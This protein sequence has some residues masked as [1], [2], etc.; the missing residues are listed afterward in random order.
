MVLSNVLRKMLIAS[1]V[2]TSVCCTAT[3]IAAPGDP[4]RIGATLRIASDIDFKQGEMIK[5]EVVAIN[6][7]GGIQGRKI[8]FILLNDKC[9]PSKGV[10]NARQL[11][12]QDKVHL[13]IGSSCSS[14]TLPIVRVTD[15]RKTP[16]ITAESTDARITKLGS[17]WIFRVP[18]S[19]RF[20]K[21]AQ[22]DYVAK[23][24]GKK[25]AYIYSRDSVGKRFAQ[26]T[27]NYMKATYKVDPAVT[28]QV[29]SK[30]IDFRAELLKIKNARANALIIS[31]SEQQ[32]ADILL[33]SYEVGIS[34]RVRR[35]F[36]AVASQQ[37]VHVL[38]KQSIRGA[39]YASSFSIKNKS[40]KVRNFIKVVQ[41][42]YKI[43]PE[44]GLA[45][46]W[47]LIKIVEQA[48]ESTQLQGGYRNLTSDRRAIR[49]ALAEIKN[50]Q[51]A[52]AGSISFCAAATPQCR[53]GNRTP[54][55]IEY[56]KGGKVFKTR[57]I[58]VQT[59]DAKAG[60]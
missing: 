18:V 17:Y 31:A 39:Y 22:A 16:Q 28:A 33:Q 51:G 23:K 13:L 60:L 53:D 3:A 20:Y 30:A 7:R 11:I 15:K 47:D 6:K 29:D 26:D 38:A 2:A 32:I 55:L 42:E 8:E 12:E 56:T 46:T 37:E 40:K 10:S 41:K 9:N 34:K 36:N 4:I 25:V 21:V 27:I 45:Q 58:S 35:V 52:S 54:V 1:S 57:K 5:S 48:L 43:S 49:N 50:Y 14:V 59:L 44:Q 19:S 24:I